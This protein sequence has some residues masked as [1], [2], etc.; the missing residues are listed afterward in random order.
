M[1]KVNIEQGS[2]AWHDIRLGRVTATRFKDLMAGDSTKSYKDLITDLACEMITN[3]A[4]ETYT[5]A[6]MER[7]IELESEAAKLYDS[8]FELESEEVG[9]CM[10]DD[11]NPLH[12]WVGISP[13]RLVG[14][15]GGLEIKCPLRK[16]HLNYIKADKLPS[17]YRHQIQSSMYVTGLQWWDFMSYYPGM[18]PFI[19]RVYPD[20]ELHEEYAIRLFETIELI[21]AE[22]NIYKQ[23]DY[24]K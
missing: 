3:K 4:E 5:N 24:L 21:K 23:Y 13:D 1:I 20:K 2:E 6:I 12:E 17:E 16:T 11:N 15:L 19:I 22:I 18:K 14:E 9:F 10:F 7:G 8:I